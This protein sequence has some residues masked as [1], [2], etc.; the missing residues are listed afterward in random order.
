MNTIMFEILADLRQS[1]PHKTD[2]QKYLEKAGT[3]INEVSRE[4]KA[5]TRLHYISD[6]DGIS[7][8]E[9]GIMAYET[10]ALRRA[11]EQ[12]AKQ[13]VR[14]SNAV[15]IAALIVSILSLLVSSADIIEKIAKL[16]S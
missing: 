1:I 8:T 16:A 7:I 15:A 2:K 4:L 11:A 13:S 12:Q 5:L 9:G 3:N 14:K 10:E 6:F